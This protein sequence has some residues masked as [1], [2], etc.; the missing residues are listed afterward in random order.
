VKLA[1]AAELYPLRTSTGTRAQLEREVDQ[2]A[3]VVNL[4]VVF[5]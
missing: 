4:R 5:K 3:H 1:P 2:T